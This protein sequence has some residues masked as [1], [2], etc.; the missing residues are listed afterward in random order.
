MAV[1]AILRSNSG[2]GELVSHLLRCLFFYA[3][4]Y[5]F[6]YSV[7]H[8]PGVTNTAAD[9]LS[10]GN[11]SLFLSLYPKVPCQSIPLALVQLLVTDRP[12]WG[13]SH[14]INMFHCSLREASPSLPERLIGRDNAATSR[15]VWHFTCHLSLFVRILSVVLSPSCLTF[16][17]PFDFIF[18]A[19]RHLQITCGLADPALVST[20]RLDYVLK[21]VR[22]LSPQYTRPRR[23]PITPSLLLR[24]Y[25]T[26][27]PPPVD[28]KKSM[29]W[30]ACCIGF[31]GFLEMWR[32]YVPVPV[33]FTVVI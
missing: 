9:A 32:V 27:S 26:W 4:C 11:L 1:V 17:L 7:V 18:S 28:Y 24:L 29:L 23:L 25:N 30:A 10:R 22:R 19:V 6:S 31:F 14:W 13:S 21:G 12:D 15:S 33:I 8:I 3:S 5:N 2:R 20:P 16:P